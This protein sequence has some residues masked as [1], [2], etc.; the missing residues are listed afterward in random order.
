[1]ELVKKSRTVEQMEREKGRE[2]KQTTTEGVDGGGACALYRAAGVDTGSLA[3]SQHVKLPS[4]LFLFSFFFSGL[5]F[6]AVLAL[7][8]SSLV[9]WTAEFSAASSLVSC[10]LSLYF[11][12][13]EFLLILR[14]LFH[15]SIL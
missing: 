11:S 6:C 9:E 8:L 10:L 14:V 4:P 12:W 3:L 15:V 1:M 2:E 5:C 13:T 7:R